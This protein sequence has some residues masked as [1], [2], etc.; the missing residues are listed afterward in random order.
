MRILFLVFVSFNEYSSDPF[1]FLL[2]NFHPEM[3]AHHTIY[4]FI[5]RRARTLRIKTFK[6]WL[7]TQVGRGF[8][9]LA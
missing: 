2:T 9:A 4:W 6:T 1:G 3:A 7:P 5:P 8:A